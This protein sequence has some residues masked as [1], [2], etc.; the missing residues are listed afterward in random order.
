M[1]DTTIPADLIELKARFD[2][3]RASRKY[4][5]E[6][7]PDDLWSE[8]RDTGSPDR[9]DESH[10]WSRSEPESACSSAS[11]TRSA[12]IERA[13][14][15]PMIQNRA[16]LLGHCVG[17]GKTALSIIAAHELKRLG[18]ARKTLAAV[19]NHLL[20]TQWQRE[21]LR[22]YPELRILAPGKAE[23]SRA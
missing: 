12:R 8:S 15:Q 18:L 19:P 6:P 4:V 14:R 5:R 20:V 11:R 10:P 1:K 2:A 7:I 22:I 21:A 16:T 13:T 9:Y 3:R 23:L 17:S